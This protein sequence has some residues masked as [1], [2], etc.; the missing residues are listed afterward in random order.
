M[1]RR[2]TI[3]KKLGSHLTKRD[4]DHFSSSLGAAMKMEVCEKQICIKE[5]STHLL[6]RLADELYTRNTEPSVTNSR[7]MDETRLLKYLVFNGVSIS[8]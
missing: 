2:R 6:A 4:S 8:N 5:L 3:T 1:K 7:I